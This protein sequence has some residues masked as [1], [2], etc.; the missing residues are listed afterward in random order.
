M[1]VMENIVYGGKNFYGF[2]IGII[3]LETIF[4][5]IIGDVGN[6]KTFNFPVLYEVVE[7]FPS[8][9]VVLN[10]TFEDIEPFIKAAKNLEK[11]DVSAITTSCGFLVLFQKILAQEINIPI[12]TSTLLLI[13][14]IKNILRD[15]KKILILTANSETLTAQHFNAAGLNKFDSALE[16]VGTQNTKTF[17]NFTVENWQCVNIDELR[18]DLFSALEKNPSL[19]K[20][21]VGAILMECTNMPPFSEEI[22]QRWKIPIFDFVSLTNFVYSTIFWRDKI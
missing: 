6:A 7:K 3:M 14:F 8:S 12:F 4:P 5:R 21:E 19:Q 16:I 17:T 1:S 13:P 10:L 9:K 2:D 22:R 11:K 20:G 15:D 18:K